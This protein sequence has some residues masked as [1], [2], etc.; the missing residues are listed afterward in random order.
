MII[1][2]NDTFGI[3]FEGSITGN[4]ESDLERVMGV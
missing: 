4:G 3:E 2:F 1:G